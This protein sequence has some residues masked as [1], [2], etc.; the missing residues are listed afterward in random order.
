MLYED[1]NRIYFK[2]KY[3]DNVV[4]SCGDWIF[5]KV[6][7]NNLDNLYSRYY[8]LYHDYYI[9]F[10]K[11][12]DRDSYYA[13]VMYPDFLQKYLNAKLFTG[14]EVNL[15]N[16]SVM[17]IY[18]GAFFF[19]KD[20]KVEG[21]KLIY[22]YIYHSGEGQGRDKDDYFKFKDSKLGSKKYFIDM[23]GNLH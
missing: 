7:I 9:L 3:C 12:Q 10:P 23:C 4:I 18:E 14:E 5:D 6:H 17:L 11:E 22:Y 19:I 13:R 15:E 8:D 2:S 16:K 1:V 21:N 20:L